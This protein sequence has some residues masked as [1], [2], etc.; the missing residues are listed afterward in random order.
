MTEPVLPGKLRKSVPVESDGTVSIQVP[1]WWN[2]PERGSPGW[3]SAAPGS[4][5]TLNLRDVDVM[6]VRPSAWLRPAEWLRTK[7]RRRRARR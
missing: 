5:L 1:L 7:H 6:A 3:H 4:T 2:S